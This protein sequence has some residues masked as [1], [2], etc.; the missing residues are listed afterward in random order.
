MNFMGMFTC[1]A[2]TMSVKLDGIPCQ[3]WQ[4]STTF[5][6]SHVFYNTFYLPSVRYSLPVTS[7]TN[8]ELHCMQPLMTHRSYSV[9]K[10]IVGYNRHIPAHDV[11]FAPLSVLGVVSLIFEQNKGCYRFNHCSTMLVHNSEFVWSCQSSCLLDTCLQVEAVV[12]SFNLP[13]WSPA[14]PVLLYLTDCWKLNVQSSAHKILHVFACLAQKGPVHVSCWRPLLMDK[15]ITLGLS[16]QAII[17]LDFLV[18]IFL[19][20][21]FY[22]QQYC[23]SRQNHISSSIT[24]GTSNP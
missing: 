24:Q 3:L 14:K 13:L 16:R 2:S 22:F 6:L 12:V 4:S 20:A 7:M 5:A 21:R 11:A 15:A 23:H 17:D 19:C 18:H 10:Q 9:N 8:S 1:H